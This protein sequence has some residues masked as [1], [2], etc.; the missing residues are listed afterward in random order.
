MNSDKYGAVMCE[1]FGAYGWGESLKL[2]KW[3]T[4]FMISHG[5]NYIVPHAFGPKKFPDWDCPPH[6]YAHGM[7]PQFEH[8]GVWSRY[9]D[10]LAHLFSNG[11]HPTRIGVL[12]HAVGEWTGNPGKDAPI[13]KV[14]EQNQVDGTLIS[15]HYLKKAEIKDGQYLI[16]GNPFDLLIVPAATYLPAWLN[17]EIARIPNVLFVDEKPSNYHGKGEVISLADL[18]QA[19]QPYRSIVPVNVIP[20]LR[21]YEYDQPDGK[22]YFLMNTSITEPIHTTAALPDLDSFAIY[23]AFANTLLPVNHTKDSQIE[24]DLQPYESLILVQTA[25]ESP[26]HTAGILVGAIDQAEVR[27][28]S[29]NEQEFCAPFTTDFSNL[30]AQYPRFSGT[31]RYYFELPEG[32]ENA[33]LAFPQ[34]FETVTVRVDGQEQTKIAPPYAFVIEKIQNPAIEVDV[35]TTLARSQRKLF[36]QFIPLEP[37]GLLGKPELYELN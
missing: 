33:V 12:Y 19:V 16:N 1:A 2:M 15:E 31:L 28:K 26:S 37:I 24:I 36:S 18:G 9:A 10:R 5:V 3:I 32:L 23:D 7:N 22:A 29:F 21:V 34:A 4:D 6:F 14:L 8:F 17:E 30:A 35:V 25:P 13:L 20:F 27:L 11:S